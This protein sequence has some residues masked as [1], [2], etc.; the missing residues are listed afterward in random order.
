MVAYHVAYVE[1]TSFMNPILL[2]L[3][4]IFS[5]VAPPLFLI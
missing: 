1:A 4:V 5:L 2:F 3:I